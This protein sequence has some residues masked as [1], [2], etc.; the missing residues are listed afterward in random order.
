MMML[1]EVFYNTSSEVDKE[2]DDHIPF[3]D[4]EKVLAFDNSDEERKYNQIITEQTSAT[5]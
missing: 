1:A 4:D 3:E 5:N 2:D